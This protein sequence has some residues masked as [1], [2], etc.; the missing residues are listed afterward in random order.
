MRAGQLGQRPLASE[1]VPLPEPL[2]LPTA[3]MRGAPLL[4]GLG[5][6]GPGRQ[7]ALALDQPGELLAGC[8]VVAGEVYLAA[9]DAAVVGALAAVVSDLRT[10]A[11]KHGKDT[12][13]LPRGK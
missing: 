10:P 2:P 6:D 5:H 1:D 3:A 12:T 7:R 9:T 11:H 4:D 13:R 8:R